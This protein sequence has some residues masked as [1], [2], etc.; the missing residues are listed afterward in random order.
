M[1]GTDLLLVMQ[2]PVSECSTELL[3]VT[4]L[5]SF[6]NGVYL[7]LTYLVLTHIH[8]V[9]ESLQRGNQTHVNTNYIHSV[10]ERFQLHNQQ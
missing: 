5:Y 6:I 7:V 2:L 8:S 10:P 9:T 1:F 4:T 3:V